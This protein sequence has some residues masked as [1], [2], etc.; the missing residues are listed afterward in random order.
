MR[1]RLGDI[2]KLKDREYKVIDIRRDGVLIRDEKTRKIT[3]VGP[4]SDSEKSALESGL[5][6][7]TQPGSI[8]PGVVRPMR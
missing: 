2:V 6:N 3:Q 8:A 4:L 7:P 5:N 1:V